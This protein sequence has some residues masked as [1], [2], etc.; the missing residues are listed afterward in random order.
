MFFGNY[1]G[2]PTYH[3]RVALSVN[4]RPFS[5][6]QTGL[7]GRADYGSLYTGGVVLLHYGDYI[8]LVT[9]YDSSVLMKPGHTFFGAQKVGNIPRPT[10]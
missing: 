6:M 8:S 2:A 7:G 9:A 4:G 1:S 3:N 5:L 10:P